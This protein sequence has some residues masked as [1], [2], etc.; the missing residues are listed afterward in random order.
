MAEAGLS[1]FATNNRPP[2]GIRG[3]VIGEHKNI[4]ICWWHRIDNGYEAN[5]HAQL[6]LAIPVGNN[7][8][9][10]VEDAIIAADLVLW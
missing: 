1:I 8:T 6:D 4:Y 7:F 2:V 3:F 10:D 9:M 5:S